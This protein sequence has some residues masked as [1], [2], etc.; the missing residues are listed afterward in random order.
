[1]GD[2]GTSVCAHGMTASTCLICRT[3]EPDGRRSRK[4]EKSPGDTRRVASSARSTGTW[5]VVVAVVFVLAASWLMAL[6]WALFRVVQLVAVA[7]IAGWVGWHL[8]V[9]HGRRRRD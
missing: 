4:P 6:A 7:V 2:R 1:M 9:R 3:L 8:G 5:L